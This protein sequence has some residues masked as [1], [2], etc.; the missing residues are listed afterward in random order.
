MK[1]CRVCKNKFEPFSSLQVVCS[2]K[3]GLDYINTNPGKN[4]AKKE[5]RRQNRQDREKL[6]TLGDYKEEAQRE[7]NKYIRARD[8]GKPCISCGRMPK[9]KNAGHFRSVGA[10]PELRYHPMNIHLQCEHCNCWKSG[11]Q[12]EY[13]VR[14]IDKIGVKNVEW[15]E[16]PHL[17]QHLTKDDC[18]EI[19]KHYKER[20][21]YEFD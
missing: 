1:R 6:K 14:L 18:I 17:L 7:C 21:K 10:A 20:L 16:G 19:K 13:R 3:C 2:Y 11:N 4:H 8:E 5:H 9:K 15:L 12:I